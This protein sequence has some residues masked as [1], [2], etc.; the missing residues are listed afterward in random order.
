MRQNYAS[1]ANEHLRNQASQR[2]DPRS[3]R[4]QGVDITPG[5]HR[6]TDA[7]ALRKKGHSDRTERPPSHL[8]NVAAAASRL[9]EPVR[10]DARDII[11]RIRQ[12]ER[13]RASA[14]STDRHRTLIVLRA[15]SRFVATEKT[16]FRS[17][18][19]RA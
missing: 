14:A 1:I 16:R 12:I 11:S 5:M 18:G 4:D 8:E 17:S 9:P 19:S 2:C 3:Y 15:A 13:Q 10:K 7:S 6:G